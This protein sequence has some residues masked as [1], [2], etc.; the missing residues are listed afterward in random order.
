MYKTEKG[1]KGISLIDKVASEK[2]EQE[3]L[4][5]KIAIREIIK[6]LPKE[7]KEIIMLRYYKQKTQKEVASIVGVS[8]VQVSR[9]ERKI[10]QKMKGR[11]RECV[12]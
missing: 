1:E 11:L 4:T 10:L 7:D 8:Q 2:D 9:T 12:S 3:M 5:N 6:D